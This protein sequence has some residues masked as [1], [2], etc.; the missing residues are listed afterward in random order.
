MKAPRT[1]R[2]R[3]TFVIARREFNERVRTKWFVV[4]TILWPVLMVG[5]MIVPALL[6]GQGTE[7][8]KVAIVDHSDTDVGTPMKLGMIAFLKW[9]VESVPP[10]TDEKS[11]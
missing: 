11:L 1:A 9:N 7:G 3:D 8:A 4:M 6:G 5:M 10:G 2:V